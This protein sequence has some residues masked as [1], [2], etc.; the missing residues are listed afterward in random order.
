[1]ELI[2][3]KI[4]LTMAITFLAIYLIMP[5]K[6]ED[7]ADTIMV[8]FFMATVFGLMIVVIYAMWFYKGVI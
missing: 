7:I 8:Y 2:V 6:Y 5:E 4:W 1:M 3:V